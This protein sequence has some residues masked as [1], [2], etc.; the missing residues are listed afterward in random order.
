MVYV[1]YIYHKNQ[2]TLGK[3]ASLMDGMDVD[4]WGDFEGTIDNPQIHK[5]RIQ[6]TYM[7]NTEFAAGGRCQGDL[8]LNLW[9]V[10]TN[11]GNLT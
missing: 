7:L 3:Y 1:P 11:S 2:P 6:L 9:S 10:V 4:L 5:P 8:V